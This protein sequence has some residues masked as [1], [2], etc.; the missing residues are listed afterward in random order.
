MRD[1]LIGARI[2]RYEIRESIRKSDVLGIY[3]AYDTKLE[4]LV[5]I[6][7]ILHS[8]EYSS[9]AIEFF[10]A[11][12][13][14][15]AKLGHP[16]I[17][18]VL[19]FGHENGNL[20]LVNEYVN[21]TILS[22]LM[23]R[24][25][26]WQSAI[27]ILLPITNALIYAHSRG[28]I[29]RD[30]KPDNIIINTDN[31]P[32]LSDFSL[33]RIIEDEETRDMTGT[34]VGL[35]SPGYISPEQGQGLSVDLRADIYSLGVIFFE[36]VTGKKLFY[37]S[38]SMEIVIQHIMSDPPKP[39]TI[40]PTLPKN[41][42]EIILNTLSKDR[43]DRY[44]SMEE[45]ANALKNVIEETNREK[46]K[47]SRRP[48]NLIGLSIAGAVFILVI[49]GITFAGRSGLFSNG[50]K[51]TNPVSTSTENNTADTRLPT[52]PPPVSPPVPSQT[53]ANQTNNNFANFSLPQLPTL[54]GDALPNSTDIIKV[55]NINSLQELARWGQPEINQLA[56]VNNEQAIVA[57]TSAGVYYYDPQDLTA[58]ALF[59]SQ[60]SINTF[61][62]SKDGQWMATGDQTGTVSVW[63]ISDG[64]QLYQAKGLT[65]KILSLE[66]S[67]DKSKLVFSDI[68]KN[69]FLWNLEQNQPPYS[70]EKR[71]TANANKVLFTDAGNSVVSG[72][73]NFQ[74]IVWDVS[75]GKLK[76]QFAA[77]QK[78]NDMAITSNGRYL[79]LALNESRIQIWDLTA[80]TSTTISDPEILTDFTFVKYL[81]NDTSIITGSA[82]GYIRA[83]NALSGFLIWEDTSLHQSDNPLSVNPVRSISI[84][85]TG[86]KFVVGFESGVVETWDF[87]AQKRLVTK[88]LSSAVIKRVTISPDDK[89]LAF[90]GGESFVEIFAINGTSQHVRVEGQLPRGMPI[91]PDNK[92][93][94]ILNNGEPL[95]MKLFSLSLSSTEPLFVLYDFPLDASVQYSPDNKIITTFGGGILK[96]WSIS[97]GLE[98]DP[99][100]PKS[101]GECRIINRLDNSFLA[102]ASKNGV[103]YS[104]ANL[105]LFCQVPRNPRLI[106][107]AFLPDGSIIALAL[108]NQQIEVWDSNKGNLKNEIKLQTPGDVLDVGISSNGQLL[109]AASAGGSIELYDLK[110]MEII[111]TLSL[112][113][114]P[115]HQVLFSNDGRYIIAGSSDGT[116]RFFGLYP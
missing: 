3:R 44:P 93:I 108:Q 72:G 71:L 61:T 84:S 14:S 35:G 31:Q 57:A 68:D 7:T 42:E 74:I 38:N 99:G 13:R 11:E 9:E 41:V 56:W 102:A 51:P 21:G 97:T 106:S 115:I 32:I 100:I 113:T 69:I 59:D 64:K 109:A 111:K 27:N 34:N 49:L 23:T 26:P 78:I 39:R 75:S 36:M 83:W 29:H 18:K 76:S 114:G 67:P 81:P 116:L 73:D 47:A 25:I 86:S 33:L 15:L 89:M 1:P 101:E 24:P 50:S 88:N 91:S 98:L 87:T 28:I 58:Q 19:D 107:E 65:R 55:S 48:R 37:A 105:A 82:D 10:L 12:A 5:L 62:I 53:P 110:T 46:D 20:Y 22:D 40:I 2:N 63:N 70:F 43:E 77:A 104:N 66:F 80:K 96:Y 52:T 54:P 60:G 8:S 6:K 85:N 92:I 90:Q 94:G 45:F 95:M 16:N 79:A 4:R 103:I 30:L 17:A 112:H